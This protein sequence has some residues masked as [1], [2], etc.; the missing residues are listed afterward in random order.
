MRETLPRFKS[1]LAAP[2][3]SFCIWTLQYLSQRII[4]CSKIAHHSIAQVGL[5]LATIL[6]FLPPECWSYRNNPPS[7]TLSR[8][9]RI[10]LMLGTL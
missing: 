9:E 7:L 10:E 1:Y 4:V 5:K 2:C 3:N 8:D 6:L